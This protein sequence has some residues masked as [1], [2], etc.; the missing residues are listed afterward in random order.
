MIQSGKANIVL[1]LE[2]FNAKESKNIVI[3][4]KQK[5][6]NTYLVYS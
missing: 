3:V 4:H 5:R 2:C 6:L 1:G